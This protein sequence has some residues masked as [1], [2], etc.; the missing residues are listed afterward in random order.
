MSRQAILRLAL[1]CMVPL[2][3][4]AAGKDWKPLFNGR[5][6]SGWQ[7][8]GPGN[9]AVEDGMLKTEGGMG[10]LWYT[11]GK[12]GNATIRVVYKMS[13]PQDDSGV[14]VRVPEKPTEPWMP[15]HR[16]Y[17]VEIGNWPD[18]YGCSGVLYSLTKALAR[19]EKPAGEWNTMEITLDGPRTV[20]VLN[21]VKVTDY[22]EGEP[23][24]PQ[25]HDYEPKRGRRPLRG[26]IGL[27]NHGEDS[28]IF[29]REVS[30]V[31]LT[32]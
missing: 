28:A 29:F 25:A 5:D 1:A 10:L 15:V 26:Y 17:E 7:H 14:F 22:G 23:V 24:P 4:A 31:P 8:V 13:H 32:K 21:G 19:P 18:D 16:G 2:E 12:I 20:V 3:C 30:L 6:L 11:R 27:Q 9:F